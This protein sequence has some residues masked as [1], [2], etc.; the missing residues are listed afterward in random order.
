LKLEKIFELATSAF[1]SPVKRQ[2]DCPFR[3][4]KSLFVVRQLK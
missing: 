2:P 1:A 4:G 3:C